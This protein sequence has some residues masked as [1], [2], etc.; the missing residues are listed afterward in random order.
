MKNWNDGKAE[1]FKERKLYDIEE[2]RK[3]KGEDAVMLFTTNR[4]PNC[5]VAK[6]FL[7][8]SGI[9]YKEFDAE[10]EPKLAIQYGIMQAPTLVVIEDG[11]AKIY[12]NASAIKGYSEKVC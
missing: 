9:A 6:R 2:G 7:D 4:C 11:L 3:R 1:E 12:A 5:K 8:E 10:K